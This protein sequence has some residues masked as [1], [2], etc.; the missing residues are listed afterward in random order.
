MQLVVIESPYAGDIERN[1][2]Y[3]RRCM[4]DCFARNE[5]PYASHG[6]YTQ[7]GVLDDNDPEQ[8]KRGIQAGF[9]WGALARV[10]V[11]YKDYG[12][13]IGMAQGI[14]SAPDSQIIEEREIGKN[15]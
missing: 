10:R 12:I 7:P 2:T 9:L 15:P 1:E 6:L 5:S 8:R 3:L 4:A 13:T 11:V 14:D